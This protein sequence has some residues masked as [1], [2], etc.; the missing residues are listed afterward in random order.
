ME[1]HFKYFFFNVFYTFGLTDFVLVLFRLRWFRKYFSTKNSVLSDI[2][3]IF[4]RQIRRKFCYKNLEPG[5]YE[6]ILQMIISVLTS[7]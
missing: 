7:N 6:C 3:P 1:D 4:P 5:K 2:K